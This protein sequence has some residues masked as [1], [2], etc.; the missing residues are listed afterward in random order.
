MAIG[1]VPLSAPPSRCYRHRNSFIP[2]RT[3][4]RQRTQLAEFLT[5]GMGAYG[6]NDVFRKR[7]WLPGIRDHQE[8]QPQEGY[9]LT[10]LW[11]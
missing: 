5:P 10:L 9:L 6:A 8:K 7:R 4:D 11:L 1:S 2:R 3:S